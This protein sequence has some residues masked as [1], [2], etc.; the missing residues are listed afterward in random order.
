MNDAQAFL[1]AIAPL[2]TFLGALNLA[3]GIVRRLL[4]RL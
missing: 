3:F 1:L 4:S 2:L